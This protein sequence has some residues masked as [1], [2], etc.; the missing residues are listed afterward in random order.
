MEFPRIRVMA[1]PPKTP[2]MFVKRTIG[3]AA[4]ML[5]GRDPWLPELFNASVEI[6]TIAPGTMELINK[7]SLPIT[8]SLGGAAFKLLH[9]EKQQVYRAEGVNKLTVLNWMIG[10][11]KPLEIP[12][13]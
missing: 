10:M 12:L 6:K 8:V 11:N 5:W 1:Y 13:E 4:N 2:A 3:W 9:N 7:S